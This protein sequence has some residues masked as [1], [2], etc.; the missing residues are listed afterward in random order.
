[1]SSFCVQVLFA[2]R[3]ADHWLVCVM[4]SWNYFSALFL[5]QIYYCGCYYYYFLMCMRLLTCGIKR[6]RTRTISSLWTNSFVVA[7][8]CQMPHKT[9]PAIQWW[10]CCWWCL[11]GADHMQSSDSN[12]CSGGSKLASN[13]TDLW[14]WTPLILSLPHPE[15]RW[16]TSENQYQ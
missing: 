4:T 11:L 3:V 10:L 1:M 14:T 15:L 8:K 2:H 12:Y 5:S 16:P 7:G 9:L 6:T 13:A